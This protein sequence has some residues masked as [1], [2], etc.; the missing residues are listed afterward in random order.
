MQIVVM[1]Y[2]NKSSKC[3]A[4]ICLYKN[5]KHKINCNKFQ[6]VLKK[7]ILSFVS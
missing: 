4:K 7:F 6:N 2:N 5:V 3:T 1:Y